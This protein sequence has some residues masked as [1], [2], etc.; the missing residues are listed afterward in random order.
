[1]RDT[2]RRL[3]TAVAL[4]GLTALPAF[5]QV[6]S[7]SPQA[8]D[9]GQMKQQESRT[10]FIQVTNAGGGLLVISDVEADC[11]CTVPTLTTKRLAPGESTQIEVRF[12]SKKFHGRVVKTVQIHSNDPTNPVV[13][14]MVN[15]E[16]LTPL[17]IDPAN[18]RLGFTRAMVGEVQSGRVTFETTE[19]PKLEISADESRKGVFAVRA[20][21]GL[22]GDPRK[23]A[24]EIVL[25]KDA[26][27]GR[28]RD[29][30]RVKTNVPDHEYVDIEMSAWRIQKLSASPEEVNFRYK[31]SFKQDVRIAPA[32]K[33]TVFRVTGA[34]IDLPGITATVDETIP[35]QETMIR[36]E[37]APIAA[38]DP[39][40]VETRG[41]MEGTLTI[42][43][44]LPDLP[45]L[46]VP[47]RYMVRM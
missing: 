37:G 27:P 11:G 12:D 26:P 7:I 46:T 18:Q 24:L 8:Y 29:N 45:V 28:L 5:G 10:T 20:V 39:R 47:V 25:D 34:E 17:I 14:F 2:T 22:D 31:R 21:N 9:F 4:L 38:D 35:N 6:I 36:L 43:T 16:V 41:R 19:L 30:V 44:D 23:A 15:A 1:M 40:A 13:D 33:G 32:E 3:F 42:R